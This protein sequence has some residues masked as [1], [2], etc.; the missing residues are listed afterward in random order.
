M[1]KSSSTPKIPTRMARYSAVA[2]SL[3]WVTVVVIFTILPL[4]WVMVHMA[5]EAPN[6]DLYFT[7]H[8]SFGLIA[9]ALIVARLVW[10]A[11]RPPPSLPPWVEKWEIGLAHATHFFLYTI[12]IIMPVSGFILSSA[13][14]HPVSFFGLFNLPQM[15]KNTDLSKIADRVHIYGQYAVYVF[16][17]AHILGVIWHV[18]YRRDGYL[19]RMLPEQ[20]NAE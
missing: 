20:V 18:A 19:Q 11:V 9:L 10:R 13:G 2:Q 5:K 16:L 4:A 3:H 15:A 7:A 6:R 8:K 14:G 17:A 1:L 12:F